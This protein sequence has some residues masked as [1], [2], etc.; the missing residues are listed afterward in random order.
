MS[1]PAYSENGYIP[2]YG[3]PIQKVKRNSSLDARVVQQPYTFVQNGDQIFNRQ[4]SLEIDG[5]ENMD[6]NDDHL[7]IQVVNDNSGFESEGVEPGSLSS[8]HQSGIKAKPDSLHRPKQT[9]PI[10]MPRA[11]FKSTD[12]K[13]D[14]LKRGRALIIN[15]MTYADVRQRPMRDDSIKDASAVANLLEN[16]LFEPVTQSCGKKDIVVN[17]VTSVHLEKL[18]RDATNPALNDYS[19]YD[20]FVLV[21]LSYGIDGAVMCPDSTTDKLIPVEQII[22]PFKADKCPSLAMKP[23][24]FFMQLC[25]AFT[26]N[27]ADSLTGSGATSTEPELRKIPTDSDILVQISTLPGTYGWYEDD[28]ALSWYIEG[29]K[30]TLQKNCYDPLR[31]GQKSREIYDILLHVNRLYLDKLREQGICPSKSYSA[32]AVTSTLTKDLYFLPKKN[33]GSRM[34]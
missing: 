9:E 11:L 18:I 4:S 12:Y 25:P 2:T 26:Y 31:R 19:D 5:V 27:I 22:E 16:L 8:G 3:N 21:V 23:K 10:S 13:M 29:L 1:H 33:E 24:L 6:T 7:S 34:Y 30:E 32:P 17:D 28:D 15:N 20:C 14:H